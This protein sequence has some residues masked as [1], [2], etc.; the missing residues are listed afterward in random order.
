MQRGGLG[1]AGTSREVLSESQVVREIGNNLQRLDRLNEKRAVKEEMLDQLRLALLV[2]R[3]EREEKEGKGS[4]GFVSCRACV[5]QAESLGGHLEAKVAVEVR[6]VGRHLFRG[7]YWRLGISVGRQDGGGAATSCRELCLPDTF[8]PGDAWT[9]LVPIPDDMRSRRRGRRLCCS[10]N[11]AL[12][13]VFY[14]EEDEEDGNGSEAVEV[15]A[16]VADCRLGTIDF[17][18]MVSTSTKAGAA[19][20]AAEVFRH[21]EDDGDAVDVVR[22]ILSEKEPE[23]R[24]PTCQT[25]MQSFHLLLPVEFVIN[26]SWKPFFAELRS[27]LSQ[28]PKQSWTVECALFEQAVEMTLEFRADSVVSLG[29]ACS[30]GWALL[31]LKRDLLRLKRKLVL[32]RG[33]PVRLDK[34]VLAAAARLRE[35]VEA[36]S[37]DETEENRAKLV[38]C[39]REVR[40]RISAKMP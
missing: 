31:E 22:Q 37:D 40:K 29:V 7:R 11:V 34:R 28:E 10:I 27:L 26:Y 13:L 12:D 25:A 21:E 15:K 23:S 39:Y 4:S 38:R 2:R 30:D 9:A 16:D 36:V 5:R 35:E 18:R 6:N 1:D 32:E 17:L 3:R 24:H 8:S 14:C 19:F 20:S 33:R